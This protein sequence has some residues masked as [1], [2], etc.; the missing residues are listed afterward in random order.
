MA[1]RRR[2]DT[3]NYVLN[4]GPINDRD[5]RAHARYTLDHYGHGDMLWAV[6]DLPMS[7]FA[8]YTVLRVSD[9]VEQGLP[10]L[11]GMRVS[12]TTSHDKTTRSI[13]QLKNVT[14][15]L[16][17]TLQLYGGT[18]PVHGPL[19]VALLLKSMG[20]TSRKMLKVT[21]SGF[22]V[23]YD[24]KYAVRHGHVKNGTSIPACVNHLLA[25][26]FALGEVRQWHLDRSSR[27]V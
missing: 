6:S 10:L 18:L 3:R 16:L 7:A 26:G 14:E 20:I 11:P 27:G 5:K 9:M 22:N 12:I 19:A 8:S 13:V 4:P 21:Q 17:L 25:K 2:F 15:P 24:L 1:T 23:R